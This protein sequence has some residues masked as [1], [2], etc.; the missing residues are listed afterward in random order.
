MDRMAIRNRSLELQMH[1]RY[2]KQ[3]L[4]N[5]SLE[6]LMHIRYRK[7]ELRNRSL[8]LLKHKGCNQ[9]HMQEHSKIV[10]CSTLEA[11]ISL[12]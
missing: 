11:S 4:R 12:S 9:Y 7:Q 5:H 1:I 3:E 6:L 8:E 10:R 2:R